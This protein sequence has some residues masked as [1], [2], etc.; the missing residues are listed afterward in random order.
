MVLIKIYEVVLSSSYSYKIIFY[1]VGYSVAIAITTMLGYNVII[2]NSFRVTSLK[3][4]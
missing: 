4:N 3:T 1:T 2:S